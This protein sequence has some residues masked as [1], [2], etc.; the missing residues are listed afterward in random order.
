MI[1]FIFAPFDT[2][3]KSGLKS[4]NLVGFTIGIGFIYLRVLDNFQSRVNLLI[5]K[6]DI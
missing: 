4:E 1:P 2:K 3:Y 6:I 5:G